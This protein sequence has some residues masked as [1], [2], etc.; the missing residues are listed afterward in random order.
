MLAVSTEIIAGAMATPPEV[1]ILKD[2]RNSLL[3]P[4]GER[5]APRIMLIPAETAFANAVTEAMIQNVATSVT[6]NEKR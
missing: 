2:A 5:S 4:G 1:S 3:A 6:M